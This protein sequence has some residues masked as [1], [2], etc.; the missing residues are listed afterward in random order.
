[1]L[2]IEST[3]STEEEKRL[4]ASDR[5]VDNSE[6]GG[7]DDPR[8][9]GKGKAVA[10]KI[11]HGSEPTESLNSPPA[12][13]WVSYD[14]PAGLRDVVDCK[15]EVVVQII[16]ES[17]DKIQ[18]RIVEEEEKR[19]A[20]EEAQ[21]L[22]GEEESRREREKKTEGSSASD[23]QLDENAETRNMPVKVSLLDSGGLRPDG[24][25][26]LKWPA[27]PKKLSFM[28]LFR[29][30]NNIGDRGETSAAGAARQ[31]RD[32]S[33]ASIEASTQVATKRLMAEFLKKTTT[34]S[35]SSLTSSANE[36]GV[37]CVSC[38]DDYN[39]KDTV[40]APCHSY[41]KPCFLRLIQTVCENEQQ[42]PPKCCLNPIPD[43]TILLNVDKELKKTYYDRAAEWNIP[44]GERLYCSSPSCSVWIR[45]DQINR[46]QNIAR[47]S[48]GHWTCTICRNAQH[49]GDNCP[50]DKDMMRTDELAEEEG[51]KRCYGCHAYVEHREACQ[52]MTCRCGAEFCYV[53]GARWRTCACTMEQLANIKRGA[54]ARRYAREEREL[55]EEAEIQDALRLVEEFEREEALKAELLRQERER[56]A[57]ERRQRELE[58]RI[59]LE[60]E[61]RQA[62]EVKFQ[63]LRE[64]LANVSELQRIIVRRGHVAEEAQLELQSTAALENLREKHKA[65]REGLSAASQIKLEER[66]ISFK[67]E[68]ITRVAEERR[69]EEQYHAALKTYWS[70]R[71]GG[72]AK[73]EASLKEFKRK[74]DEGFKKWEKWRDN[75]LEY[76]RWSVAEEQAIQ[77]ELMEETERRL[78]GK[79][80]DD[81]D[82]LVRRKAAELRWVEVV[83]GERQ[84][85]LAEMEV[86]ETENGEDVDAWFAEQEMDGDMTDYLDLQEGEYWALGAFA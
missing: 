27:K 56:L 63:G 1:M 65:D 70:G 43:K 52:H 2:I 35:N 75:E 78:L 18:A 60:S 23:T 24:M 31:R 32:A 62:V 55:Q 84:R 26:A 42:W 19:I 67:R 69:V 47:C 72:E 77:M 73:L 34:G 12:V 8:W 49:E 21:K 6:G 64:V 20:E 58:E 66:E 48:A 82:A 61:R 39:P 51:W 68:Y 37:E 41:C 5:P 15:S 85:M 17:I 7:D 86:D 25:P 30:L 76:Y 3:P 36:A 80:L 40:K 14:P 16:Q 10:G 79:V 57:E 29:R 28:N 33:S 22:R 46:A 38:L 54:A 83:I 44:I 50:Q 59:R 81:E 13:N 74:M 71:E 53:C 9:K 4:G 11:G 45:P